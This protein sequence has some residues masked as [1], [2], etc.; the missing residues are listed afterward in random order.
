ME[1][2]THEA[3]RRKSG[4]KEGENN[5]NRREWERGHCHCIIYRYTG[6]TARHERWSSLRQDKTRGTCVVYVY[7]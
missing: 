7:V 1:D 2:H 4:R 5:R 3:K 6:I